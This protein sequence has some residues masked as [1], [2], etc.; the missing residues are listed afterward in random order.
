[1][2]AEKVKSC[3]FIAGIDQGDEFYIN[4]SGKKKE[5]IYSMGPNGESKLFVKDF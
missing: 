1:M 2:K 3:W 5:N 4:L